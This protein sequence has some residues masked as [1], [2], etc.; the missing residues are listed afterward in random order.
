MSLNRDQPVPM[1]WGP[2]D[3]APT[4]RVGRGLPS[5][6]RIVRG[7]NPACDPCLFPT[8]VQRPD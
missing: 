3:I 8:V 5:V 6:V 7:R 2:V 4:G 1:A